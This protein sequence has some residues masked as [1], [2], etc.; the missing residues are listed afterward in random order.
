MIDSVT[1]FLL[2]KIKDLAFSRV[3]F[4]ISRRKM[5]IF[6]DKLYPVGEYIGAGGNFLNKL[7]IT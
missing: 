5:D 6:C 3:M 7:E 1:A 2:G 4:N